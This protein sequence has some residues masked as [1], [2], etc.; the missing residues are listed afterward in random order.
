M[1]HGIALIAGLLALLFAAGAR[2]EAPDIGT[3]RLVAPEA[4]CAFYP[5][6]G[7]A[8]D[9]AQAIFATELVGDDLA[10]AERAYM[11]LDGLLR[12]LAF[13][14]RRPAVN[15]ERRTYRTL[16]EDRIEVTL[17]MIRRD[18]RKSAVGQTVLVEYEGTLGAARGLSQRQLAFAG[19]C[20]VEPGS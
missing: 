18:S 4:Y 5:Q 16:G 12:E 8:D 7:P 10:A 1:K 14:E 3:L 19:K 11:R 17:A 9:P 2:A 13:I 6:G 15:G 20:G